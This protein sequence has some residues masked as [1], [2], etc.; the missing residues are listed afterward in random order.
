VSDPAASDPVAS[1][2]VASDPAISNVVT[3][4]RGRFSVSTDPARLDLAVI[5]GYL[6]RSYWSPGITR[7][8]V[9]RQIAQSLPFGLY[10]G[11]LHDGGLHDRGLH[12]R[13]AQI[14]FAR[15]V[16]D[17]TSFAYLAD[18]FVLETHRGQGLGVF[19][20]DCVTAHPELA[21]CRRF[22]LVTRDAQDLYARFG[23]AVVEDRTVMLRQCPRAG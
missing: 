14:G 5:H 8:M 2:P 18:V 6:T 16:T 3:W 1:D 13:P 12:D 21:G 10:D 15:V 11:G 7:E 4:S 23:F 20:V 9:A 19:L 17:R 22:M